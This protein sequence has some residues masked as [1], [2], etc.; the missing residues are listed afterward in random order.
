MN[1]RELVR[2]RAMFGG[3]SG[4]SGGG[5]A[6]EADYIALIERSTDKPVLP[7]GLTKIGDSAFR[8]WTNL[9]LTS[10]PDTVTS[11]GDYAF[12]Q[13]SY[14]ALTS[15]PSGLTK[16]G[17]YTFSMCVRMPLA[18]IPSTV[19][20]IGQGAFEGCRYSSITFEGTPTTI[21]S[22]A[23]SQS[24]VNT[25]NVPWA[26]GEVANAPWGATSATINYN[27]TGG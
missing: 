1:G 4:G 13:C 14:L 10:L 26:E 27:Y 20:S 3:G 15:L 17:K 9:A 18:S 11:I 12:A 6:S 23:F 16:I 8:S 5:G 21:H 7:T 19:T 22:K 2:L 25:I 24:A